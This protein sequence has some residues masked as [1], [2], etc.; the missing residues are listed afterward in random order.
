[1]Q[2]LVQRLRSTTAAAILAVLAVMAATL[3]VTG[4]SAASLDAPVLTSTAQG[5]RIIVTATS[6]QVEAAARAA[7]A[8]FDGVVVAELPLIG[9]LVAEVPAESVP[10]IA[11]IDGVRVASD[12]EVVLQSGGTPS[13]AADGSGPATLGAQQAWAAGFDGSG[14]GIAVIDTGISEISDLAGR[15]AAGVDLTPEQ[16]G[17]DTYGHG[18]PV[19]WVAAGDGSASGGTWT[20]VA[21][22]A[23]V[24]PVK[25]AGVDGKTE[26]A[27]VLIALDWVASHADEL[28]VRVVNLSLGSVPAAVDLIDAA[29]QHLWDIGL[30]VVVAAGNDGSG[31]LGTPAGNTHVLTVGSSAGR[32]TADTADDAA[33][34]W[35]ATGVDA[36]GVAKPDLTAPGQSLVVAGAPGSWAYTTHTNGHLGNGYQRVSGTS[37]TAGLISGSAALV[38]DAH[39]DWT[40]DQVLGQLGQ[41]ARPI[42]GTHAPTP[43]L[44]TALGLD[45]PV[46]SPV[47]GNVG[48][49]SV[50]TGSLLNLGPPPPAV[51]AAT[52]TG[53]SL[54]LNLSVDLSG[55]GWYG[56][57]WYGS[58]WYGSGWYGSGWYGSGWYG[59]GWYGSGWYGSGWY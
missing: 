26:I 22:G 15:V 31:S 59:S 11:G 37:F 51:V 19:A 6:A 17:R 53:S 54:N 48:A 4:S 58:G 39:P 2:T 28:G 7:I 29:V 5:V 41:G 42:A 33:A 21:P 27:R 35:S 13:G 52:L 12:E 1:M 3:P 49:S 20:G 57:G 9:G 24:V 50:G 43:W 32:G 38:L 55:S 10:G 47:E 16:N 56:S 8:R 14:V 44:P 23:H 45:T 25:I 30:V 36:D 18:T 40:P 46:L 34:S